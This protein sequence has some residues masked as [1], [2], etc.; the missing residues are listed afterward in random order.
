MFFVRKRPAAAPSVKSQSYRPALENLEERAVPSRGGRSLGPA[1]SLRVVAPGN[2]RV[3][4]PTLVRVVALDSANH[5]VFNF[6]DT[7]HFTS[8]DPSGSKADPH[9]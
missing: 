4:E 9:G 5:R 3:G 2:P 8:S 7:I 6:A 1:T